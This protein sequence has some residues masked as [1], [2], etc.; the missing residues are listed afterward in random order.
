MLTTLADI[1]NGEDV[2]VAAK[3]MHRTVYVKLL[4]TKS[5]SGQKSNL[6]NPELESIAAQSWLNYF[7]PVVEY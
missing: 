4:L 7:D 3:F 1:P 6:L 5:F 2:E